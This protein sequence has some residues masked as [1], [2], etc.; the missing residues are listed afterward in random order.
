MSGRRVVIDLKPEL[1]RFLEQERSRIRTQYG[2]RVSGPDIIRALLEQHRLRVMN[3]AEE[4]SALLWYYQ[5]LK[6][7]EID[8]AAS[9]T[10]TSGAP[11]DAPGR[12]PPGRPPKKW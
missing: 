10:S 5:R 7:R 2:L 9:P 8:S 11:Q 12:R 3:A 6:E 1:S 4:D